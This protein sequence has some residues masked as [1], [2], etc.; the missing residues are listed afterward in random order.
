MKLAPRAG[1]SCVAAS[2]LVLAATAPAGAAQQ[3]I[4]GKLTKRGF[5]VIAL[6][7]NGKAASVRSPRGELRVRPPARRVTLH[8]R[9]PDGSYAGPIV[10][11]RNKTGTRALVGVTAAARLGTIRIARGYAKPTRPLRRRW[12]DATRVVRARRGVPVGAGNFGLVRVRRPAGSGPDA[13]LDG[14]PNPLDIDDDGDLVLDNLERSTSSRSSAA[15]LRANASQQENRLGLQPVLPLGIDQTTNANAAG[16]TPAQS[17]ARLAEMGYLIINVIPGDSAELDC[18]GS[19]NPTPPP[20]WSGGLG[21]CTLGGTG[22][23]FPTEPGGPPPSGG[24]KFPECCDEDGDGFG[25][26]TPG[27]GGGFF[28]HEGATTAQVKSGDVLIERVTTNGVETA[29]PETLQYVF[30]TVPALVSYSDSAGNSATVQYP[31]AGPYPTPAE[32]GPGARGNG[33]PVAAGSDGRIRLTITFWRPQRWSEP[34]GGWIDIGALTYTLELFGN[35]L[36]CGP[37]TAYSTNDPSLTPAPAEVPGLD[38]SGQ[39]GGGFVDRAADSPADPANRLT[40]TV[41]LTQCLQSRGLAFNS[42]DEL[43]LALRAIAGD[44]PDQASQAFWVKRQ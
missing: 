11:G 19:R 17:D 23:V 15:T 9:A 24:P 34:S 25:T 30:A 35:G 3:P 41:D 21:Y 22:S 29:Y 36:W 38:R 26:L 18:G 5:T 28:L 2:V 8:L 43:V 33:F 4:T 32:A 13:D 20:P 40:F 37:Q 14:V 42:G 16:L 39:P 10:V 6:A 7:A 12:V 31:V 44:G 27:P 1:M